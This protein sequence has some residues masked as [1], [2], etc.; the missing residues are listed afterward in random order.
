MRKNKYKGCDED[1]REFDQRREPMVGVNRYSRSYEPI[2]SELEP[3]REQV[4]VSRVCYVSAQEL[5]DSDKVMDF[6]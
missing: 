6:P 4:G 3:E 2:T 1:G 5:I